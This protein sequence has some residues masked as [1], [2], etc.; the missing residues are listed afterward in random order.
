[1]SHTVSEVV[2][3]HANITVSSIEKT[4]KWM[5]DVFGWSQRWAGPSIHN[6]RSAHIGG[7]E[8]YIAIYQPAGDIADP[9]NSYATRVGLNHLA[10]VVPDIDAVEAK[11]KAAGFT[12]TSHADYEPGRR[13]YFRDHDG[14]EFEVVQYD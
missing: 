11:V 10:V 8:S 6:G 4:A 3:E 9:Q 12:P 1:M 5:A 13:F 14:V 7:A 2:L